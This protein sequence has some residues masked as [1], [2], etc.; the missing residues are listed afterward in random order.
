MDAVPCAPQSP[1][2]VEEVSFSPKG[3]GYCTEYT[4]FCRAG[5]R[6]QIKG[7]TGQSDELDKVGRR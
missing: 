1:G 4:V 7:R 5:V 6:L 2:G 3:I